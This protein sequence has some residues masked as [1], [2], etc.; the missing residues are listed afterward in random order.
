MIRAA[1]KNHAHVAVVVDPEDYAA[2]IEA[3]DAGGTRLALRQQLAPTA[4]ARTAAYDAAVSGWMA[5]ALGA[6]PRRAAAP[7]PGRWRRRCAMARTRI[8]RRPST[9]T[10]RPGPAWPPPRSCRA[11]S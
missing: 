11:R 10:A 7:L 6:R 4:Y 1:A 8:R 9:P 5:G 3:L 2:L